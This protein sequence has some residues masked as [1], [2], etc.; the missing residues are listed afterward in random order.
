MADLTKRPAG[1]QE[2]LDTFRAMPPVQPKVGHAHAGIRAA[3][4]E[5]L[6][7]CQHN[8]LALHKNFGQVRHGALVEN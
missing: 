6:T 2:G 4:K 5:P 3:E 1:L 8:T 7:R